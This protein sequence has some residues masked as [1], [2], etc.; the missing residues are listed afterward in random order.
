MKI[1]SNFELHLFLY[2]TLERKKVADC[3]P[4]VWEIVPRARAIGIGRG[5]DPFFSLRHTRVSPES[6][7]GNRKIIQKKIYLDSIWSCFFSAADVA[8]VKRIFRTTFGCGPNFVALHTK[9]SDDGISSFRGEI[10]YKPGQVFFDLLTLPGSSR[11]SWNAK[12]IPRN[13]FPDLWS[14]PRFW[15]VLILKNII[16]GYETDNWRDDDILWFPRH[17]YTCSRW[18]HLW[19]LRSRARNTFQTYCLL[20]VKTHLNFFPFSSLTT[21]GMLNL[22]DGMQENFLWVFLSTDRSPPSLLRPRLQSPLTSCR[23]C[24]FRMGHDFH[25]PE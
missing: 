13:I 15:K 12:R 14:K 16:V 2:A 7:F 20:C 4:I 9:E 23:I 11:F 3:S 8:A 1:P 10:I 5:G 18:N 17:I 19:I 24:D 22:Y 6:K 25:F 21:V